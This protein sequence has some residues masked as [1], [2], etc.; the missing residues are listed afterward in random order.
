M[1]DTLSRQDDLLTDDPNSG[2]IAYAGLVGALIVLVLII[3]IAALYAHAQNVAEAS[4]LVYPAAPDLLALDA[5]QRQALVTGKRTEGESTRV[6]VP[7]ERAIELVIRDKG[8]PVTPA[9]ASAPTQ[10]AQPAP[11]AQPT[12]PVESAPAPTE[13]GAARTPDGAAAQSHAAGAD[14]GDGRNPGEGP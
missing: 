5:T 2:T 3:L 8:W 4:R 6:G 7:I 11:P 14:R 10:P 9:Q 12:Q 1:V 13:S